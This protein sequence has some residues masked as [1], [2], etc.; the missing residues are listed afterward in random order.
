MKCFVHMDKEAIAV[1]K[2]CGKAM[3]AECSAYS[4]HS[5]ICPECRKVQFEKERNSL[6][7]AKKELKEEIFWCKVKA[8]LLFW[9]LLI[10]VIVN[11]LK[12]L[13]RKNQIKEID[14]RISILSKEIDKLEIAL[15]NKGAAFI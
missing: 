5:G 9:L 13:N 4:N 3:C 14:E 12:I 1:C 2:T 15:Q 10:P 6:M 11:V 7:V 8:I